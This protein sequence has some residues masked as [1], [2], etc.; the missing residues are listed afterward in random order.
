M[1][2]TKSLLGSRVFW[3]ALVG[4]IAMG[5]TAYGYGNVLPAAMQETLISMIMFIMVT[6]FR[7]DTSK[8]ITSILPKREN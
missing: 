4:L 2:G 3:T 1:D 7:V 8:V 6:V 5:L